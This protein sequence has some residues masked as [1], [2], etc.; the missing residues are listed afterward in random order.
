MYGERDYAIGSAR[1]GAW[2]DSA[3]QQTFIT[4]V[5]GWMAFGLIITAI[6]A[7]FVG[8]DPT[9]FNEIF[10]GHRG[11][12]L[13]LVFAQFGIAM[14]LS[15]CMN[16]LNAVVATLLFVLYA[17]ITG[18]FF[19]VYFMVY[20]QASLGATFFVTAGTFGAMSV[21]GM[22]TKRD[23]TSLGGFLF[24]GLLGLCIASI[25]NYFFASSMLYWITTY[26]GVLIFVLF[27]AYDTQKM[28]YMYLAGPDGSPAAQKAAIFA[29]FQLYL[30][31][32]ILFQYL[33]R[34][35]GNRRSN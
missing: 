9:R 35:L 11:L 23:L 17:A 33:L 15:W 12:L 2:S 22:V 28:K 6:I 13:V 7:I 31:F 14:G 27:T 16:Y 21:Y 5:Y 24:M 1:A 26:A 32:V 25:V 4:K 19:S 18:L 3:A 29:A 20:T 10:R 30:D 34:I 8:L